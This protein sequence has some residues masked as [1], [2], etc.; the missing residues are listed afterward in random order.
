MKFDGKTILITGAAGTI[1]RAIAKAFYEEGANLALVDCNEEALKTVCAEEGWS[2]RTLLLAADVTD[3]Q[4]VKEYVE[5]CAQRFGGIDVFF[6]NAGITGDRKAIA[7]FD[8]EHF[9]KLM[10]INVTGIALG[11]KYVLKQ[12]YLQGSGSVINTASQK[13]KVFAKNSADYAASKSAVITLTKIAALE[14][15]E[16]N[17]RV[18]CIMPG[19]VHSKML[20]DVK[21]K[22]NPD[23]TVEE[24]GRT[25]GDSI[26]IG[27][28]CEPE[29]L[30]KTVMFLGSED[31]SYITG[32]EIH[33]DGGMTAGSL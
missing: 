15:A 5:R 21:R 4:Q 14:S 30:A 31:A 23:L 22:A 8:I 10:D 17:V 2:E 12:M 7:D 18:N 1:G 9:R 32:A 6:N 25:F 24:I 33:I 16:K 27:R 19:I 3:E 20:V 28:W 29:E 11:L 13:G 26:P